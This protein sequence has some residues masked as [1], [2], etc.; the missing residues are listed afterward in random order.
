MPPDTLPVTHGRRA[1][2]G[3]VIT[4][5]GHQPALGGIV[6]F[7]QDGRGQAQVTVGLQQFAGL[8]HAVA[9]VA[10]IELPQPRIHPRRGRDLQDLAQIGTGLP[11]CGVAAGLP[12]DI[13]RPRPDCCA[14][15]RGRAAF[16]RLA[17]RC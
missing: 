12:G 2:R 6:L 17:W 14:W 15:Q 1:A 11:L 16:L 5:G 7:T 3:P 13:E 9:L 8:T 10:P 4:P